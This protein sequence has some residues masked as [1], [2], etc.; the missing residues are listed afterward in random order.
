MPEDGKAGSTIILKLL[1]G[2]S[3]GKKVILHPTKPAV[4]GV[5]PARGRAEA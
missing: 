3:E 4:K 2:P 1:L 5:C